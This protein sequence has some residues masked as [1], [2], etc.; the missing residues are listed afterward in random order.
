MPLTWL[1]TIAIPTNAII[2]IVEN[3]VEE[4][5]PFNFYDGYQTLFTKE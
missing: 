3:L 4:D 5:N 2:P 1:L